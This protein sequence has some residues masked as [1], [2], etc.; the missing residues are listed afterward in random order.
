MALGTVN[1]KMN[2][3]ILGSALPHERT[4]HCHQL[5]TPFTRGIFLQQLQRG[6]DLG[7][8]GEEE[9]WGE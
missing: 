7:S 4:N 3:M 9:S 5:V 2:P 6:R 1:Y 8:W